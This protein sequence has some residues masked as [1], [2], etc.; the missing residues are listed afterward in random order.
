MRSN[1][2]ART[3]VSVTAAVGIA[4]GS[5]AGASAG[6]AASRPAAGP[7]ASAQDASAHADAAQ[8]ASVNR[9]QGGPHTYNDGYAGPGHP[10]QF[11]EVNGWGGSNTKVATWEY[12]NQNG[13]AQDNE[14]WCLERAAEGGWYLHPAYA[15]GQNGRPNLCLDVPGGNYETGTGLVVW[16]CNGRLNQRFGFTTRDQTGGHIYAMGNHDY[17]LEGHHDRSQVTLDYYNGLPT[18][19][20]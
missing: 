3:L 18:Y 10:A 15:Y 5:M 19:W 13:H 11:L 20:R 16:N 1:A 6:F 17:E 12:V 14:R 2:F 9:C 7:A 8:P 4:A